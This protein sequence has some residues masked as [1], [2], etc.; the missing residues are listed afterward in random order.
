MKKKVLIVAL[1]ALSTLVEAGTQTLQPFQKG[2]RV[3]FAGNSITDGGHYHSYIWLYYMTHFPER[4]VW[5]ANCGIGGDT[6]KQILD[7]LDDDV[8]SKKPT[9]LTYSF[10][11]ND[12]G[13]WEYNGDEAQAFADKK[14]EECRQ[15]LQEAEK[16]FKS[17][18]GVKLVMIGTSPYD[19]TSTFNDNIY[20]NK[21]NAMQRVVRLQEEVARRNG[22]PFVDFNA[23]MVAINEREQ[24]KDPTF[25]IIGNDRVHP[26]NDGHMVMAYLFLKAQGLVGEKVSEVEIDASAHKVQKQANC[27][28]SGL[29][30]NT[31]G[32]QYTYLAKSLPLPLD[33]IAHGW[34]FNNGAAKA[35]RAVP[36]LLDDLS[37]EHL[38]VKGL[39][40]KYELS[41]DDIV[42]DTL[43]AEQLA[44]G[45]NMSVYRHSPQYQQACAIMAL[46]EA[47]WEIERRFRDY[48]WLQY[49]FFMPK[50]MLNRTDEA[51]A[52]LFRQE[53][54]NV[55][56]T[57]KKD[58]FDKM[59]HAE[60][61]EAYIAQMEDLVNRIYKINKPQKRI[62]RL[63]SL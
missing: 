55:F 58:T 48:A 2:D 57:S 47:R 37:D 41:I 25:T 4:R 1:L 23:P 8:L 17:L 28:V 29:K 33:T 42:L 52:R 21:N 60:V 11:M 7:R 54:D 24:K 9:V 6:G 50:G 43:S 14:V 34:G 16:R 13:Y 3:T 40:G 18:N 20:K 53:K 26:D 30:V 39:S 61:R 15:T 36:T 31:E 63:R 44:K 12:T 62:V 35:V 51:A 46:N 59:C 10:G 22:W 38:C 56:V 27:R 49:D 45:L 19:Q 5:M 32:L